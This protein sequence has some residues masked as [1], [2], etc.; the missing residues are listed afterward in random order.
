ME[1]VEEEEELAPLG[2]SERAENRAFS[3]ASA[4]WKEGMVARAAEAFGKKVNLMELV[5]GSS[6]TQV[7]GTSK[8]KSDRLVEKSSLF[9]DEEEPEGGENGLRHVGTEGE[10]D[11]EEEDELFHIRRPNSQ[12]AS[13]SGRDGLTITVDDIDVEESCRLHV[14]L[15][16]VPDW[17]QG[18]VI[19][20]VRDR[21]VTGDWAKAARRD[22]G[23]AEEDEE[24]GDEGEDDDENGGEEDGEGEDEDVFGDFEDLETGEKFGRRSGSGDGPANEEGTGGAKDKKSAEDEERRLKKLALRAK[25]DARSN[26]EEDKAGEDGEEEGGRAAKVAGGRPGKSDQPDFFEKLKEEMETR[27][28]RTKAELATL[29]PAR[30]VELEGFRGGM[31]VRVELRGVPAE[32]VL[33]FD[34]C[35]PILIGGVNSAEEGLGLM[36]VRLKKHRWHRKILKNRDPLVLS[37]GWRRFQSIPIFAMEDRNARLRMLKYTPEHMHCLATLWGP[38]VPPGTGLIAFTNPTGNEPAAHASS[39]R[40]GATGVVLELQQPVPVVKKLKLVGHPYKIFKNTAFVKDLFSSSLEVARFEGA[41]VRTV[42]GIRG[43]VK[44]AVKAGTQKHQQG[45]SRSTDGCCRCTFEDKILMS[46][47]VFLRAWVKVPIPKF[48]NPVTSLLQPRGTSWQGMRTV[49]QLRRDEGLAIPV[50]KDSLYKPVERRPRSF[51]TLKI[52]KALQAALPFKSKP[53]AAAPRKNPSLEQKRAV[54]LE[55]SERKL[56]TLVQQLNT[57]RNEKVK[58]RKVANATRNAAHKKKK[59][60]EEVLSKVR[61]REERRDRYRTEAQQKKAAESGGKWGGKRKQR[62][63]DD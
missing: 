31:Y 17:T 58:K 59:A 14:A 13:T 42:S 33:H 19:G 36:Q 55:P 51:N 54:V 60:A 39:F 40:V 35:T 25:F 24:E 11:D 48:F 32:L 9:G 8:S 50:N 16:D 57:I 41:A 34:P 44:K 30:R 4:Q 62:G 29:E 20:R 52:P 22:R 28:Q 56:Y 6:E 46:D 63:D 45:A 26:G 15:D 27:R 43:Q 18:D 5:Y 37:L 7:S 2:L 1:E 49:G 38:L 21:F 47:I 53:K 12:D 3:G 10:E 61:R 23:E